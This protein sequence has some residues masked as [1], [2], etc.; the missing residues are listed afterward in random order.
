MHLFYTPGI[1]GRTH[2]LEESESKHAIRVLR[3]TKG[4]RVVLVDGRGGWYEALIEEDHPKRCLLS[5]QSVEQDFH[6]MGYSLHLAVSPTKSIERFEWFLEKSTEIG[7]S[8]ITPLLCHRSERRQVKMERLE[9]ILIS[10]MKQSLKAFK[11][12]L[13]EPVSF[14]EFIHQDHQ[15]T[16]GIAACFGSERLAIEALGPKDPYTLLVGPEGDFTEKEVESAMQ[17]GFSPFHLGTSRLRTETAAVYL[18]AAVSILR[19]QLG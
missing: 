10:A 2:L 4:E 19:R 16:R 6:P 9:R 13:H 7:I 3:L 11:P 1:Q 8:E 5:I 15:G 17:A 14:E 12:I 18:T